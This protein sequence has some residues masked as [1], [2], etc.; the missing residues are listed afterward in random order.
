[1]KI[2]ASIA[3]AAA[4][5]AGTATGASA[6]G[7]GPH[8]PYGGPYG[9]PYHGPYHKPHVVYRSGPDA[10]GALLAGAFLGLAFGALASQTYDPPPPAPEVEYLPPPHPNF[11]AAD[12]HFAWCTKTYTSYNAERDSFID[13]QG[14]ERPCVDPYNN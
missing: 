5:A 14:I 9:G 2:L 11:A 3:V 6:G 8:G 12:A 1:M 4:L 10:G 7:W 13:F